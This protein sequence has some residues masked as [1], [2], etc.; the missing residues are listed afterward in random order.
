MSDPLAA[1]RVSQASSARICTCTCRTAPD[2]SELLML[3]PAT[4]QG[5]LQYHLRAGRLACACASLPWIAVDLPCLRHGS[6]AGASLCTTV[7]FLAQEV[8]D[9]VHQLFRV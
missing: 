3:R 1:V 6:L 7:L 5:D 2:A 4:A 8:F 9:L